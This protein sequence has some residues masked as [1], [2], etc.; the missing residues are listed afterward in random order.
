VPIGVNFFHLSGL[1]SAFSLTYYNQ[2][3]EFQR[4]SDGSLATGKDDFWL[5]DAAVSYRLPKRYGVV[6]VGATN[7]LD[8]KFNFAELD[9]NNPRIQP[10]RV[11]YGKVTVALP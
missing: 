8:R 2:D 3:G 6:S 5:V 1:S 9:V 10:G 7:L 11:V 4:R